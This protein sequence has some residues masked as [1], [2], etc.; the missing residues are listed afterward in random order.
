MP[1]KNGGPLEFSDLFEGRVCKYGR[2]IFVRDVSSGQVLTYDEVRDEVKKTRHRLADAVAP[3]QPVAIFVRN[4]ID[5]YVV[6]LALM[7][8]GH[9]LFL[10]APDWPIASVLNHLQSIG[11]RLL[12]TSPDM[13][14]GLELGS[15]MPLGNLAGYSWKPSEGA[16]TATAARVHL[17]TSGTTGLN[18]WVPKGTSEI[19]ANLSAWAARLELSESD[20]IH[21]MLPLCTANGFYI[22]FLMPLL[23]GASIVLDQRFSGSTLSALYDHVVE[24]KST[25]ISIVPTIL[26]MSN[27]MLADGSAAAFRDKSSVRFAICGTA[28]LDGV[29]KRRFADRMGVPVCFNYGITETL[30]I[31]SQSI[32]DWEGNNTGKLLDGMNVS[33]GQD[34]EISAHA[35]IP[36]EPYF[37]TERGGFQ[38]DGSFATGDIGRLDGDHLLVTGRKK[39]IVIVGGFNVYPAEVDYL[40][41]REPFVLDTYTFG[42]PNPILGQELVSTVVINVGTDASDAKKRINQALKTYLPP[43][44]IPRVEVVNQI[45][46]TPTGKPVK[47][48]MIQEIRKASSAVPESR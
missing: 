34:G 27:V 31:S 38:A 22:T 28:P 48:A 16:K 46:K 45:L 39:D 17:A 5:F 25:V 1:E 11:T 24:Y 47:S 23:C 37:G 21:S 7:C 41:I 33:I 40:I 9:S 20:R 4:S 42:I 36:F 43:Y 13:V 12:I 26:Y 2:N 10:L 15:A 18:K 32:H 6:C 44:K 19:A 30:F 8:G 3:G 35:G 14:K 29:E